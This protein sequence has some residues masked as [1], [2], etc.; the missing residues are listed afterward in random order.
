M[1][2]LVIVPISLATWI[3][4]K[5]AEIDKALNISISDQKLISHTK[6]KS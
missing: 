1:Q 6:K 2:K 5:R 4:V 3:Q